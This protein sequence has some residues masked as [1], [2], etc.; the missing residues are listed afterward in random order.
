M[1]L[2]Q[3]GTDKALDVL[4]EITPYVVNITSD[5]K[6]LEPF[7]SVIDSKNTVRIKQFVMVMERYSTAIPILLK[8][9]RP[10]IYGILSILN[11]K[12][13]KEIAAQKLID[14][15]KQTKELFEDE[16]LMDFFKSFFPQQP[17]K[18]QP[19]ETPKE[20]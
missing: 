20:E 18:A 6:M 11:E 10:D 17:P 13:V 2:S 9:H 19:A 14:T 7:S 5:E 15:M 8:T 16:E 12:P 4:C 1:R 3:L